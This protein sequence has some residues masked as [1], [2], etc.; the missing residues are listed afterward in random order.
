MLEKELKRRKRHSRIRKTVIGT[1]DRPRVVVYKS[2]T[3]TYLQV[4]NDDNGK[5][6]LSIS[7]KKSDSKEKPLD[8]CNKMGVEFAKTLKGKKI[9]SIVFDR[10]GYKYHGKVKAIAEGLREGGILF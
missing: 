10:N 8:A 4:A 1:T 7:S 2:N 9:D 3:T 5:I 6:T